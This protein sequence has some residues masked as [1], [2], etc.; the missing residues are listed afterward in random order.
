MTF[1][2]EFEKYGFIEFED[3]FSTENIDDINKKVDPIIA[4]KFTKEKN[5]ILLQ[6]LIK[7]GIVDIV[8]SNNNVRNIILQI[9]K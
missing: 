5:E 6:D 8:L 2:K 4:Y 9:M 1:I 3:I 7:T